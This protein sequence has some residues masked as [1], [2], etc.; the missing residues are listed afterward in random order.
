MFNLNNA[1]EKTKNFHSKPFQ[2]KKAGWTKDEVD[3]F[4]LNE[5]F[6]AVSVAINEEL[7][8][9]QSKLNVHGGAIALGKIFVFVN[10]LF[11]VS[12]EI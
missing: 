6:A 3:L 12:H 10:Y 9:D 4:E 2:L 1:L 7:Q 11:F 8:I 5:A